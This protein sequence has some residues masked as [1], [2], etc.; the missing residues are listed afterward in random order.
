MVSLPQYQVSAEMGNVSLAG[1]YVQYEKNNRILF[2]FNSSTKAVWIHQ[3][4]P[5]TEPLHMWVC[6]LSGSC[7][8][9]SNLGTQHYLQQWP[10][11][12]RFYKYCCNLAHKEFTCRIE[13]LARITK[14]IGGSWEEDY[15]FLG[16][17]G[18]Y[19]LILIDLGKEMTLNFV[20]IQERNLNRKWMY[21]S[22]TGIEVYIDPNRSTLVHSQPRNFS[23]NTI[24]ECNKYGIGVWVHRQM[25]FISCKPHAK[26]R[27]LGIR[28]KGQ[29]SFVSR[30]MA[31]QY[32]DGFG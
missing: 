30:V 31:F 11:Y 21:L 16:D 27:Y 7:K 29:S 15:G 9:S 25:H 8:W 18:T 14:A 19:H 6:R 1:Y 4:W 23:S 5:D 2:H 12:V 13:K 26:G 20:A 3:E 28:L 10:Q 17:S 24:N 32:P 22:M